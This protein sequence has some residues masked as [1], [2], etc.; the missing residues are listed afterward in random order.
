M[1]REKCVFSR[2]KKVPSPLL[3]R[4]SSLYV[5][6]LKMKETKKTLFPSLKTPFMATN[7]VKEAG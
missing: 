6:L 5:H 4:F 1:G 2:R 7:G 3:R